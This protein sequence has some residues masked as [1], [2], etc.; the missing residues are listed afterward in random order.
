[1]EAKHK[2]GFI[3]VI[4]RPNVGKSTL[5]NSLIGQKIAIMS[6]KPQTTR[7]RILCILTQPDAQ[8]VFLDTPGVHKPMKKLGEYMESAV[9]GTLQEVDAVLFVVDAAEKPGPGER[10]IVER[11]SKTKQPVILV[12]NKI[13][14]LEREAVLPAIDVYSKLYDFA[15]VVP[16]SARE[17]INLDDLLGETKK[18][19]PD[20]PQYY[21]DD[22]VTDQPERLIAA[23]LV[24]EK[25]LGLTR[26]EVPHAV[27]VDVDEMKTRPKGDVYIRA[28]I[29]VERDSQKGII[30]GSRGAMLKEIGRL[31][32]H[33]IE[34]LLG[35]KVYLD[36]WVKVSKDWRNREAVLKSLG[37]EK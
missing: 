32:R 12:V 24:R 3:A 5:I 33:D 15:G 19:L 31:A 1:M 21:P 13:D 36:L 8:V 34:A 14:T 16:I 22:M 25:V 17:K 11:L 23:E 4:G 26:D 27:A 29:Y 10:Y 30:I 35:S 37:F 9:E 18:Y 2:S 6:D 7:N 20:G 28:T